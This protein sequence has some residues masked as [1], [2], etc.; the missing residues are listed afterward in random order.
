MSKAGNGL[1]GVRGDGTL[2]TIQD[3][4]AKYI[5]CRECEETFNSQAETTVSKI[6]SYQSLSDKE[7]DALNRLALILCFR[8]G[9]FVGS[10]L[11]PAWM[12]AEQHWRQCILGNDI[13]DSRFAI[14]W[15]PT[16]NVDPGSS[17]Q[18]YLDNNIHMDLYSQFGGQFVAISIPNLF[19]FGI[20]EKASSGPLSE[21]ISNEFL[22]KIFVDITL[23]KANSLQGGL[24]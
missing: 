17:A 10:P 8:V 9:L 3:S 14:H 7:V 4:Y 16:A 20:V 15:S 12:K 22:K 2:K 18:S 19:I 21:N 24:K 11:K 1:K 23:L 5:F 6:K 13:P